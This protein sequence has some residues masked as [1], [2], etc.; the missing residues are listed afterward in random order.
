MLKEHVTWCVINVAK[1]RNKSE[2]ICS[3]YEDLLVQTICTFQMIK[4]IYY[5]H[6]TNTAQKVV[7]FYSD[8][9]KV[10]PYTHQLERQLKAENII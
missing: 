4:D 8:A 6:L 7:N 2:K 5:T 10:I 3:K 9:E 1:Y